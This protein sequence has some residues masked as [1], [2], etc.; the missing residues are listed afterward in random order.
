MLL[1]RIASMFAATP[2]DVARMINS[3]SAIVSAFTILFLFWSI[4]HLAKKILIKNAEY[5]V[6]TLIAVMGSGVVG[7]LAY[8]FSDTFWF[9]AVEG[10]VYATSSLFTALVFWAILKWENEAD[11][12]HA[13]RWIILIAYLMGLS[14]GV[15][16]L[17]L[18]AIPAIVFV[19]YFR[20]FPITKYGIIKAAILSV[21]LV[22]IVMYGIIQGAVN[23]AAVFELFLVNTFG[24]P[25]NSGIIIYLA[26]LATALIF[27]L[28][29]SHIH[30]KVI[31]NTAILCLMMIIIGYSS[32]S[33]IFIRSQ[34]DPPM[35]QND[36]ETVFGLQRYLNREQYGDRPLLLGQYYNAP[37]V[38][39]TEGKPTY[40]QIDGKYVASSKKPEYKYDE[41]FVSIFPRMFSNEPSH[42]EVY[43]EWGKIEGRKV[44]IQNQ[45]GE[46][47]AEYIPSFSENLRFFFSYQVNFMYWRYFMWNFAGRQNDIQGH[48][49]AI[50]GN[51]ITGISFIDNARLGDQNK[52]P[53]DLKKNKAR[54][55]FY[56]LPLILGL[57][58]LIWQFRKNRKDFSIVMLLFFMTGLAIVIYLNQTPYQPRE[59]D[60]AYAGSFYAFTIW[61]G[62]GVAALFEILSK[63]MNGMVAA[64]AVTLLTT[65]IPIQMAAETW[66]DHDRSNRYAARDL[67]KN[68]LNSC[69]KNG[70]LFTNGD[71]DTFPLWYAQEVEG[72][73]TDVRVVNLSYIG[74]DWYID[75]LAQSAYESK[76]IPL[77]LKP[78]QY[79]QGNND[80]VYVTDR[81]KRSIDLRRSISFV[82]NDPKSK[83]TPGNNMI[84][85]L[86]SRQFT[87]DVDSAQ[88]MLSGQLPLRYASM[89]SKQL[90]FTISKSY[91]LKNDLMVLD[92]LASNNWKR[93][94]YFAVTVSDDNYVGLSDY[95]LITGLAYQ[96]TPIKFGSTAGES[97]GID[98]DIMYNKLMNEFQ[99]GNVADSNVYANEDIRRMMINYRSIFAR[100]ANTLIEEGKNDS[101]LKVL[102]RCVEVIPYN[103]VPYKYFILLIAEGYLKLGEK[104]KA[105]AI[106]TKLGRLTEQYLQCFIALKDKGKDLDYEKKLYLHVFQ[107]VVGME[108]RY[109]DMAKAEEFDKKFQNYYTLIAPS[110]K[111][112]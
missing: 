24:L 89:L 107:Q 55:R 95:F 34:A 16:L 21:V 39:E 86:P 67:S 3:L 94:M 91:L 35:D 29:Y 13:N 11:K 53:E 25:Y 8:T 82:A 5:N 12:K 87:V 112:E 4:T 88:V 79:L 43:K 31:L 102:D 48:G 90:D 44:T 110:L 2:A 80:V 62:L 14:I 70:I 15:H 17:N 106:L 37:M 54:N 66:D 45:N 42:I 56:A 75:Q 99:W 84:S 26:I 81:V 9:S 65:A 33:M 108:R 77:I 51:W 50:S 59:R 22:A 98:T 41:R 46:P 36:P 93:P 60:Y 38:E 92:I 7:A 30:T 76:P 97:G 40:T 85:F 101:A 32:Y 49:N 105:E 18:L 69:E 10:E 72:V 20:K 73:R 27:G 111:Q 52:L 1:G 47:V 83:V 71:N 78:H 74:A 96:I 100:L 19:Y 6:A 63:K 104:A 68:Y 64:S 28:Y 61:I 103:Q 58:G 23:M 109:G 57:I